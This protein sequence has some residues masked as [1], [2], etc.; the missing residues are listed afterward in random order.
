MATVSSCRGVADSLVGK[1]GALASAHC[2]P[3]G[4]QDS[5][6]QH[7]SR[8]KRC[9]PLRTTVRRAAVPASR[10]NAAYLLAPEEP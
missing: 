8:V 9:K 7:P 4:N 1:G 2:V 5:S 10:A 6:A 3:S